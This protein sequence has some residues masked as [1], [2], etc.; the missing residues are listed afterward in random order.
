MF[1]TEILKSQVI[2]EREESLKGKQNETTSSQHHRPALLDLLLE[3]HRDG[4]MTRDE[5]RQQVDTFMF[6]VFAQQLSLV[7]Y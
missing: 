1:Q 4:K 5:V 2:N 7:L 3:L 6:E